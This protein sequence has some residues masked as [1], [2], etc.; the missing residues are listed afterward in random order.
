MS[1]AGGKCSRLEINGGDDENY[2]DQ[3]GEHFNNLKDK[4][5]KAL[6]NEDMNDEDMN[7]ED[8][9][10]EDRNIVDRINENHED[11]NGILTK[12]LSRGGRK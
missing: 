4:D 5:K 7:V 8:M 3:S 6:N 2:G 12:V 11:W 10:C 9:N 1:L